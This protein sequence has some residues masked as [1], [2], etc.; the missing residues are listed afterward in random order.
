[1]VWVIVSA[2]LNLEKGIGG[3][4]SRGA[5]EMGRQGVLKKNTECRIQ[6]SE[7]SGYNGYAAVAST[8]FWLLA[9]EFYS[10]KPLTN[11]K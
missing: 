8:G 10:D 11:D 5:G 4:E 1:M 7:Y 6:N 2:L 3:Q 9:P